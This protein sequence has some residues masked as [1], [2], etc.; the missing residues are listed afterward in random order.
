MISDEQRRVKSKD[1]D[2][3]LRVLASLGVNVEFFTGDLTDER[4]PAIVSL[5]KALL[6]LKER[7]A[8][9]WKSQNRG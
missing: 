9:V 5:S 2:E 3:A 4:K 1:W 6:A 7:R 8:D